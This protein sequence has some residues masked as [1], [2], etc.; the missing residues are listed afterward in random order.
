MRTRRRSR[1]L[2]DFYSFD[3]TKREVIASVSI[4]AIMILI[5]VLIGGKVSDYQMD[6]NEIYNKALK[7]EDQNLFEYGMRT[8]VGNA[9][10]YGDLLAVDTVTYPEIGGGYMYIEKVK[11][12]YT[13][14]T[15]EVAHTRTVN[16]KTETYYTTETYWTWDRVGSEDQICKEISFLNVVFDVNKIQIPGSHY[17]DTIKESSHVRY[18]YYVVDTQFT[19]TIFTDLRDNTI[20]DRTPFYNNSSI[21]DTV[22]ILESKFAVI[23]FWIFWVFLTGA[24]IFGFYYIDN[25]WLE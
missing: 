25:R 13:M 6:R 17:I 12:R 16:G 23:G 11:E 14:H 18:K 8:N 4:L 3:I 19:G 20:R 10:V 2:F 15:R 9:F 22:K 21:D 1:V 5:G 24:V 7:I